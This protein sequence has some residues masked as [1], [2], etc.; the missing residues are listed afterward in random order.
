MKYPYPI[1]DFTKPKQYPDPDKKS[2][3][4]LAWEFLRRNPKYQEDFD[5]FKKLKIP[6]AKRKLQEKW[7]PGIPI[8]TL[9]DPTDNQPR[10]LKLALTHAPRFNVIKGKGTANIESLYEGGVFVTF[11]LN[12][13]I[14]RQLE[15]TRK[16]LQ[17]ERKEQ[18]I[19]P[20]E[21]N[22]QRKLFP[23]YCRILDAKADNK[24]IEFLAKFFH[25]HRKRGDIDISGT[26]KDQLK[27]ALRLRDSDYIFLADTP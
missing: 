18:K 21:K 24:S 1:K 23:L 25:G 4:L 12:I 10:G 2:S 19:K 27:A 7:L 14:K 22:Y 6:S 15:K 8:F 9:F 5:K 3:S 16:F 11:N 20:I 17:K 13:P 26:L